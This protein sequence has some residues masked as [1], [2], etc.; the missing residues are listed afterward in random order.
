MEMKALIGKKVSVRI[1]HP[2]SSY[3]HGKQTFRYE[4][5]CGLAMLKDEETVEKETTEELRMSQAY[6]M[7]V[8]TEL[9]CFSG[10]I[11]GVIHREDEDSY[12]WLVADEAYQASKENM[13]L[14]TYFKE[15]YHRSKFYC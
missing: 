9:L 11:V 12:L 13:I 10:R 4:L 8:T 2:I 15:K 7:G 14:A 5:N 6:V 1:H 3:H